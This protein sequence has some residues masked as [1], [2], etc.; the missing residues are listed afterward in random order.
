[1]MRSHEKFYFFIFPQFLKMSDMKIRLIR[2][3]KQVDDEKMCMRM[4]DLCKHKEKHVVEIC[5]QK[6]EA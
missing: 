1:M 6:D 2:M 3:N 4:S 5:R